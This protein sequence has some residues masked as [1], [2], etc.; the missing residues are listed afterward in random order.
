MRQHVDLGKLGKVFYKWSQNNPIG[1]IPRGVAKEGAGEN[2]IPFA[3]LA[4]SVPVYLTLANLLTKSKSKMA[5]VLDLGCGTGRNI[6]FVK[7]YVD[8]GTFKFY[9]IDYSASC[10]KYAK[11]QYKKYGV[12]YI[13]HDGKK[14]PFKDNTFDYIVSSHV[15]EHVPQSDAKMYFS[16]ISRIL[17]KGGI[18]VVGTPN[19]KYCQDLF[20]MNPSDEK[21][22]RLILPHL[23]EFYYKELSK[24]LNDNK[25]F[26]KYSLDQTVNLINRRLMTNS[27]NKVKPGKGLFNKI[28]FELYSL[29]RKN[30]R[31][32]DIMAKVGTEFILR[33]MKVSYR[34]LLESTKY[35][36]DD[37]RDDG[38]N[39][40]IV[41]AK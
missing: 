14:L 8:R 30:S 38:D 31:V 5:K 15:L 35:L 34:E 20:C 24:L 26:D 23:H 11:R 16:E 12:K 28:K 32:Q 21:K 37:G 10:I 18:A 17:K 1:Q 27:I 6:S 13:Q 36:V 25:W 33:N 40:I 19:R 29:L 39:F 22:F 4:N 2:R 3:H 7:D 41:A 9:G